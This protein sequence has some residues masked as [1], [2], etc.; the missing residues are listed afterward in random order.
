MT[1]T[2]DLIS[3]VDADPDLGELLSESERD[4]ARRDALTRVRRLSPG[5]WDAAMAIEPETHHRGFLI[6]DGLISREVDVLARRCVEL[7]GPGDVLRPW[8]WDEDGS[9]VHAEVGWIVLEPTRLAVLDHGLVTRMNPWPQLGVELFSRGTRRAHSL[10]VALAIAH[11]Q[12]V[13]DRLLLT[14]WHLAERWGRVRPAGIVLPLPLSHQRL[15]DLV[16]AHR[17]SVTTAMGELVRAGAVSRSDGQW[18]LHGSPPDQLRH[19]RLVAV[20][21]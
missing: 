4:R 15:A 9:H 20:M 7:L 18:M 11:H 2:S 5:A 16:G 3:I 8:R 6:I 12:R 10:A 19:H 17:P 21:S 13:D 14:L 1:R